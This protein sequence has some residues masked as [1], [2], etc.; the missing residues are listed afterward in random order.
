MSSSNER[1]E[2]CKCDIAKLQ[3][4]LARLEDEA[5]PKPRHGD[6]VVLGESRES[7]VIVSD[8]GCITAYD[9]NGCAGS[10]GRGVN[11]LYAEGKY[12][13]IGNVFDLAEKL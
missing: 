3:T 9:S 1:I 4:E 2:Q 6:I 13:V 7:R 12:V 5:K 8:G 11:E 10:H